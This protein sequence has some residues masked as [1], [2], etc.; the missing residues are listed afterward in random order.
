MDYQSANEKL[1]GRCYMSRKIGNNT[2]LQRDVRNSNN[3]N[4]HYHATDIITFYP[5]GDVA[6]NTGGWDTVTTK[7]RLHAYQNAAYVGSERGT[8]FAHTGGWSNPNRKTYVFHDH[9]VFKADGSVVDSAGKPI[10]GDAEVAKVKE[11]WRETDRENARISRW[12]SK[13]RGLKITK[14]CDGGW[15]CE[16]RTVFGR[17]R[18]PLREGTAACGCVVERFM[19]KTR[20]TVDEIMAEQNISVRMAM[21]H[22]Y[23]FEKF[24]IDAKA[25]TIDT[26]VGGPAGTEYQLIDLPFKTVSWRD[27]NMRALKMTCP[28]TG[29]HF[30][31]PVAPDVPSVSKALDWYFQ[32]PNYLESVTQES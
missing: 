31:S 19:P 10:D 24:M 30:I 15:R 12:L 1:Q 4:V 26:K 22:V 5:N 27:R 28:S 2:Y 23:G 29:E 21:V 20:L 7:Q 8:L 18:R 16:T 14:H 11:E 9:M 3:I 25:K 17:R 32:T 13:A 6:L